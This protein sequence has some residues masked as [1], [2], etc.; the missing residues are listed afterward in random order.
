MPCASQTSERD[1]NLKIVSVHFSQHSIS[2]RSGETC[3][4]RNLKRFRVIHNLPW[5][6][7][8]NAVSHEPLHAKPNPQS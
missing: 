5:R 7:R 6:E 8:A 4:R 2:K 3:H 1:W